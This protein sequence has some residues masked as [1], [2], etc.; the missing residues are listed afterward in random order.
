MPLCKAAIR[1]SCCIP[2]QMTGLLYLYLPFVRA[3]DCLNSAHLVECSG[4]ATVT[5]TIFTCAFLRMCMLLCGT[6]AVTYT[7]AC[8]TSRR[9]RQ[10]STS[11]R[12]LHYLL[13]ILFSG[14]LFLARKSNNMFDLRV[15]CTISVLQ[16]T[17]SC[18]SSWLPTCLYV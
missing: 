2:P 10:T 6:R 9:N 4:R 15:F 12:S 18:A 17:P 3:V 16:R 1:S 5:C 7:T 14:C 11:S 13:T 8:R